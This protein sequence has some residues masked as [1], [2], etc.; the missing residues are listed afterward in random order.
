M[1]KL[2]L[3]LI[4]KLRNYIAGLP[5]PKQYTQYFSHPSGPLSSIFNFHIIYSLL[6]VPIS[7]MAN[8]SYQR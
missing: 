4:P 3:N 5:L 6:L 2:K 7:I 8:H 1:D